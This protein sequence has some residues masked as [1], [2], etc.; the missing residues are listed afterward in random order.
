MA[1]QRILVLLAHPDLGGSRINAALAKAIRDLD[2]VT[3]HD[4][5]AAYPD[6]RIDTTREQ[7]L[8]LEH[9]TVVWQFPWHWYSLPGVLKEW[10]DQVLS[11]GFAYGPGGTALHGKTLQLVTSI[12]GPQTSY[13]P[14]GHN[15]FTIA[16]LLRPIDATAH[17]TGMTLAE[18]LVLHGARA[19]S[20]EDLALHAKRYRELLCT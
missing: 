19:T 11:F 1:T 10:I 16:E 14:A 6:R 9:D 20:D 13:T 17:L 3:V 8:L 12:G 18:P 2:H 5:A 7:R 4:L 15:R